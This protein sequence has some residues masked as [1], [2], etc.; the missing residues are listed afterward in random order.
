MRC[1]NSSIWVGVARLL[2]VG[3]DGAA[4]YRVRRIASYSISSRGFF[5]SN[6]F[7]SISF[8]FSWGLQHRT[9]I[10]LLRICAVHACH[11]T[12]H[13]EL[14]TQRRYITATDRLHYSSVQPLASTF[15]DILFV[16][17]YIFKCS[18]FNGQINL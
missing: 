8:A 10:W 3:V 12:T 9:V 15:F 13:I 4:L 7:P 17:I 18:V 11:S 14:Y 16:H 5:Y 2:E 1:G 6:L